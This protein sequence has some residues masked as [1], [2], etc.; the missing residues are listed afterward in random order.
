MMKANIVL[1]KKIIIWSGRV[2][3]KI[4]KNDLIEAYRFFRENPINTFIFFEVIRK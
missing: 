4:T 3:M 2:K 1:I